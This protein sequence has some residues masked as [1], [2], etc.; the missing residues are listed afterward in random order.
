MFTL[1]VPV[2]TNTIGGLFALRFIT[3]LTSSAHLPAV[4]VLVAKW[5]VYEEKSMWVGI[6]YAGT[7][8][9]TVISIFTSGLIIEYLNWQSIFY[10]HGILPLIWCVVFAFFFA[11]NPESQKFISEKERNL[12]I[13]SYGHRTPESK[14]LKVPWRR[15]FTSRPFW[16]LL[17]TNTFSNFC[18]YFLLTQLPLYMNKILRFNITMVSLKKMM[19]LINFFFYRK[20]IVKKMQ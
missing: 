14:K 2:A 18:W 8:V 3:G 11:D 5:V 17:A 20:K 13:K 16:A 9:G 6:I 7:S 12:L 19:F 1:L 15:I 10:I 4:N